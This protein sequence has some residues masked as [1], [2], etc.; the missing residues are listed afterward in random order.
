MEGAYDVVQAHDAAHGLRMVARHDFDVLLVDW[1]MPS[2]DGVRF[3]QEARRHRPHLA[4]IMMTGRMGDLLE[5]VGAEDRR[6]LGLLA[7][8]WRHEEL[9]AKIEL[10]G[11][12]GRMKRAVQRM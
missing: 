2:M 12:L 1:N 6:L 3:V 10:F 11:R 4:C 9:C 5:D 7:K 8:P